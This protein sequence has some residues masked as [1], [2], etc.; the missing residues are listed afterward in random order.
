VAGVLHNAHG[1]KQRFQKT[2]IGP[3][4]RQFS[5]KQQDNDCK[6]KE[7]RKEIQKHDHGA[8][9]IA[10]QTNTAATQAAFL[11]IRAKLAIL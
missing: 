1:G 8:A 11:F 4:E 10:S 6:E 2:W 3:N 7:I 5:S 9:S